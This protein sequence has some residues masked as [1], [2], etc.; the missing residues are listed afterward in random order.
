MS[1]PECAVLPLSVSGECHRLGEAMLQI[2]SHAL[3][4]P[5][6]QHSTLGQGLV[7]GDVLNMRSCCSAGGEGCTALACVSANQR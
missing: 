4:H 6:V 2:S 3:S 5:G 1:Q 7:T